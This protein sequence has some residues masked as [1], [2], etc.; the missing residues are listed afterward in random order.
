MARY[1]DVAVALV[2]SDEFV[3]QWVIGLNEQR[4]ATLLILRDDL[5]DQQMGEALRRALSETPNS[6]T[7][8]INQDK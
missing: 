1:T 7:H 8:A 3:G 2:S 4:G 6:K 5:T